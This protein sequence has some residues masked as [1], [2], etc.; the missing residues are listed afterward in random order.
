MGSCTLG[1]T[2][3][4]DRVAPPCHC[5]RSLFLKRTKNAVRASS[6]A[7]DDGLR[8]SPLHVVA[9]CLHPV[10]EL[11]KPH[12]SFALDTGVTAGLGLVFCAVALAVGVIV[13]GCAF[14]FLS[15]PL[16]VG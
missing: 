3:S 6:S 13:A 10:L 16:P 5:L 12:I 1:D 14:P 11:K 15:F 9:S 4:N 2:T 7:G 8:W